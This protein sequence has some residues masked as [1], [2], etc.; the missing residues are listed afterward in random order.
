M[1]VQESLNHKIFEH[2]FDQNREM[3]ERL[4]YFY[5]GSA[6]EAQDIVSQSFLTLWERRDEVVSDRV[7]PYLFTI[8]KNACLDYRRKEEK[9][10]QVHEQ[11]FRQE[12]AMMDIYTSTIE[13]RDPVALFT[14]EILAIYKE[15]LLSLP[16]EQRETWLRSRI[17]GLT[18]KEIAEIM[19]I[20]YK[21][22]DK[23]MQQVVK[24]LRAALS[25]YLSLILFLSTYG[26][27]L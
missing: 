22:V 17:D 12:R 10:R 8:V 24:K 23:N 1:A 13:S 2:I 7:L 25:E 27:S 16:Q 18:Y 21:R 11:I 4:A 9:H 6:E 15:T 26:I 14:G 19:H 5:V 20:P 3:L